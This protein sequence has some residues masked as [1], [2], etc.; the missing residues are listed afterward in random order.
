MKIGAGVRKLAL[1]QSTKYR[2]SRISI[3]LYTVER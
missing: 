1:I 2:D 3:R